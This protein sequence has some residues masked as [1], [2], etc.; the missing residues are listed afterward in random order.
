MQLGPS[1]PHLHASPPSLL[2]FGVLSVGNKD[3]SGPYLAQYKTADGIITSLVSR[4][5]RHLHSADG[6]DARL[7]SMVP[8]CKRTDGLTDWTSAKGR[9]RI[10][11]GEQSRRGDADQAP[12]PLRFEELGASPHKR[13]KTGP[14]SARL[15]SNTIR[16]SRDALEQNPALRHR[17]VTVA[18]TLVRCSVVTGLVDCKSIVAQ[19][20]GVT[21]LH[22]CS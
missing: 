21:K 14:L 10:L 13:P 19:H 2:V 9:G 4:L 1:F 8:S 3:G 7:L 17:G 15:D 18:R 20:A 22:A 5:S 11:P 12:R 6:S 16:T